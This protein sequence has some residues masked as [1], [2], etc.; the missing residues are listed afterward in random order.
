M[1]AGGIVFAPDGATAASQ[2]LIGHFTRPGC[3]VVRVCSGSEQKL[4][5]RSEVRRTFVP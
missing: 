1:A 5:P 4:P 3:S 2:N